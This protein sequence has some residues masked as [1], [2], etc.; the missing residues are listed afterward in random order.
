M[1]ISCI[2]AATAQPSIR[3]DFARNMDYDTPR[4][5]VRYDESLTGRYSW[6]IEKGRE[7][8][9]PL[10]IEVLTRQSFPDLNPK[11][12]STTQE[13]SDYRYRWD[14][15]GDESKQGVWIGSDLDVTF[16]PGFDSQR[17]LSPTVFEDQVTVQTLQVKV[18]P[19][20]G[21]F[22]G[23]WVHVWWWEE[24]EQAKAMMVPDSDRPRLENQW[25]DDSQYSVQWHVES[26]VNGEE[27][28]F[29]LQLRIENRLYP[30][31][32][33]CKPWVHVGFQDSVRESR[34]AGS[35]VTVED[36]ILGKVSFST[37]S[38]NKWEIGQRLTRR[39]MHE[40][41]SSVWGRVGEC[42]TCKS[43]DQGG[44]PVERSRDFLTTD[45]AVAVWVN[46]YELRVSVE[47]RF[48][49][50][51]PDGTLY[52]NN[53]V[54]TRL[55]GVPAEE[56]WNY[57]ISDSINI[58]GDRPS[59]MLGTW[60]VK[61]Y[62]D[63]VQQVTA[64][65]SIVRALTSIS[66]SVSGETIG[67]NLSLTGLLTG[68]KGGVETPTLTLRYDKPDGS[69]VVRI[70]GTRSDGSFSDSYSPDVPGSWSVTASW[71]G[72][73]D[74]TGTSAT[75]TFAVTSATVA[76]VPF[77]TLA[78]VGLVAAVALVSSVLVLTKRRRAPAQ[79]AVLEQ[80]VELEPPSAKEIALRQGAPQLAVSRQ[81][82]E[83]EPVKEPTLEK[84]VFISYSKED[85][86]PAMQI[87]KLLEERGIGCW[88]T[89][90][91]VIPGRSYGE[92][93]INAIESTSAT[94]LVLSE[95]ANISVHVKNEIERAV[96]K[97]K[98]IIPIRI[99]EVQPSKALE[100]FI[101]SAQWID[102]FRPPL[103]ARIDA[104]AGAIKLLKAGRK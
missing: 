59:R 101:S 98:T 31:K 84:Q 15:S 29:S 67:Q 68:H 53:S 94:V 27:Y 38:T 14:F 52:R 21:S 82:R 88:I 23:F 85:I 104:L 78:L 66:I 43:I 90:R 77:A 28:E 54:I 9:T 61:V 50:Y 7:T 93:I 74:Y 47:V 4:D 2:D 13:D 102:A 42:L 44:N 41:E 45:D 62:V 36:D 16:Q 80:K 100:L 58:V 63:D 25:V 37:S 35:T 46:L 30:N 39:V 26:P 19:R 49:W 99:R 40:G 20:E 87:C 11:P 55:K 86:E 92:E 10:T 48:E 70:V 32:V 34:L 72:D 5:S 76:G 18:T 73:E 17:I 91:D 1:I 64:T 83:A 97:G 33:F 6:D 103:E 69:T 95:H 3:V 24:T 56:T 8:H 89:P 81:E 75:N 71:E 60:N 22:T 79:M 51:A 12:N 65:F 96:S 57:P